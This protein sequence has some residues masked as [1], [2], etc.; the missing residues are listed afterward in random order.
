M[1]APTQVHLRCPIVLPLAHLPNQIA[2]STLDRGNA[3]GVGTR[4]H[5]R[6]VKAFG[7]AGF[8]RERARQGLRSLEAQGTQEAQQRFL[9]VHLHCCKAESA[10]VKRTC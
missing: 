7:R 10:T 1:Q 9:D 3:Q 2:Q 4:Q 8:A 6:I 5:L